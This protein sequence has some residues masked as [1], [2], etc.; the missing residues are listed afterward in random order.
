M[1]RRKIGPAKDLHKKTRTNII[2][3][4]LIW[5][6]LTKRATVTAGWED[7]GGYII[8]QNGIYQGRLNLAYALNWQYRFLV[9]ERKLLF[10]EYGVMTIFQPCICEN[11][12]E[13]QAHL[14][15]LDQ[16]Y[17]KK[18]LF[19]VPGTKCVLPRNSFNWKWK[20][21]QCKFVI[22]S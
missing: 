6:Q 9:I 3:T 8:H 17:L 4:K 5:V 18:P 20:P 2:V 7:E 12:R 21:K 22:E 19:Q 1:V 14:V 11:L 16:C 15:C 13:I 10:S